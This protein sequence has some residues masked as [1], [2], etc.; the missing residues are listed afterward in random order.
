M[1]QGLEKGE[2]STGSYQRSQGPV[3]M[4]GSLLLATSTFA[5]AE[6]ANFKQLLV[7]SC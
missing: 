7:N 3:A 5:A 6:A 1:L 2:Q 4:P